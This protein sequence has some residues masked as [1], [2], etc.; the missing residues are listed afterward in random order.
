MRGKRCTIRTY[1]REKIPPSF[2]RSAKKNLKTICKSAIRMSWAKKRFK[3][4]DYVVFAYK[5][6]RAGSVLCGLGLVQVKRDHLFLDLLCS[7]MHEG[8]RILARVE[9]LA[10]RLKLDQV[11]LK[12]LKPV[13]S[14]YER[15][16]YK[17]LKDACLD[18]RSKQKK[19][20][21]KKDGWRMSKCLR[22]FIKK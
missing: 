11:R 10:R 20:G 14:Y 4:A 16:G 22:D 1:E 2:L 6:R 8:R 13:I 7:H 18:S 12:S 19:C 9:R 5:R 15:R 21:T 3:L 17:H